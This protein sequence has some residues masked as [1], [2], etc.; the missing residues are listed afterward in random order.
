MNRGLI[1]AVVALGVIALAIPAA[2]AATPAPRAEVLGNCGKVNDAGERSRVRAANVRCEKA[3]ELAK[4]FIQEDVVPRRWKTNNPAGCEWFMFRKGDKDE[5]A[6]W[7][8]TAAP[9]DFKL[10]YFTK[11]RGCES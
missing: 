11:F 7:F 5:F 9:V 2:H 3:R 10:V 6:D 4:G 8:G 1:L